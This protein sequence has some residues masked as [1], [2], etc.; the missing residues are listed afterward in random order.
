[1]SDKASMFEQQP[2][3]LRQKIKQWS[4]DAIQRSDPTG[5]F[6]ELYIAADGNAEQVPWAQL[7]PHPHIQDWL[8]RFNVQG[9]GQQAIVIGCGLGDDAE[10]LRALGFQVVA[11]DIAP[12]AIT[13][14]QQRFPDST[15]EYRVANL[16]AP[17]PSWFHA[18][19]LVVEC[20]NL[21]ALPLSVRS[22][23]IQSVRQLVAT[24]GTLLV[25]TRLRDTEA[26]PDGPP[27][28][29]SNAELAEFNSLGL[30]E[31]NRQEFLVGEAP[32][33]RQVWVEYSA[34]ADESIS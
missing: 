20:R 14:C 31:V 16:L 9:Q 8:D 12:T 7:R 19:D 32:A 29:L 13:W 27:W 26:E 21:Q 33:V 11:F 1:M 24:P 23:A 30:T 5:W 18:F 28:P 15:V 34:P 17:D 3:A 22:I 4:S 2:N 25:V 10:A 6:E